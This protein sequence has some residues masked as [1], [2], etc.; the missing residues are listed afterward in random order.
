MKRL[1][2]QILM[3]VAC[4][5]TTFGQE[6]QITNIQIKGED[7]QVNYNLIDE[8]LDRS[9]SI[10]LYTSEDNF[11]R[12]VEK[13][14]GDVGV[15]INVGPNKKIIWKAKEE[16]GADFNAGIKLELK[17][18]L[19]VPFIQLD[20]IT[21]GMVLKRST[22]NDLVWAGGR[23]DNILN[24]ELYKGD[25]LIK[26]FDEF[27]NTGKASIV[28]PTRV[29]P[30]NGYQYRISDSKNRDEVVYSDKFSVK[31]KFPL[32]PKVSLLT[33]VGV[34]SYFVIKSLIPVTEPDIEGP[35]SLPL[36]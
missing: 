29:K 6:I 27:P 17:G 21:E 31:R 8:R 20:G 3:L 1:A 7:I 5:Y 28:I 11:I 35:P 25:K 30:G 18:H 34:A 32:L 33:M 12:P 2:S 9:Y 14:S 15:D 10:R 16:L 22:P 36:R 4:V 24:I 23:G 13:V 19:Y 26:N